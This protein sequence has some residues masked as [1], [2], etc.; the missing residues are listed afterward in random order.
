M[1]HIIALLFVVKN[2][3]LFFFII[4]KIDLQRITIGEVAKDYV[5]NAEE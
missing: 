1:P 5:D 2:N 4:M 3:F